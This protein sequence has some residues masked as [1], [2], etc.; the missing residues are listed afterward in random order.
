MTNDTDIIALRQP[1][2]VEDPLT[3]IARNGAR[4]ML[5]AALRAEADAF[6][7]QHA[8]EMLPDG[9]QRVVR[10]GYGP[11]RSI[12]TGIGAL[13][14]QRP[15]VRDRATDVPAEKRVRFTSAILPKWARRSRS[16]DALLPVLYLRG[17][18]TGDFQETLAAILGKDAPNLSPRVISRLTGE[19]QQEYDRELCGILGDAA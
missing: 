18:S 16:L 3:E 9:R 5:A 7:A 4:R 14:V 19:W 8:E 1:E 10:H 11:E 2:T 15:K 17:I 12:Q 6:V 13:E